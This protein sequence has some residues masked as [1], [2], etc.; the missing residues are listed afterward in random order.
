VAPKEKK[1]KI[2]VHNTNLGMSMNIQIHDLLE[3]T[4]V[5][6]T[7]HSTTGLQANTTFS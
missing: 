6:H 2:L 5:L 1:K 3:E 7:T 4:Q